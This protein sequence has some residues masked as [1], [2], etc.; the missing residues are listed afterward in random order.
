MTFLGITFFSGKHSID[1]TPSVPE[2]ITSIKI[3]DG[4][5]NHLFVSKNTNLTTNNW[6]DEWDFNTVMNA[7]F[8]E[9]FDAGNSGFSLRNTD[10]VVIR[11]RERLKNYWVTLFTIPI[12]KTEDFAINVLDRYARSETD[13]IYR[14][15]STLHGIENSFVEKEIYSVF[16][17]MYLVDKN[18]SY[19]SI[20]NIEDCDTTQ[21]IKSEVIETYS[22]YPTVCSNS[23]L[24]YESGTT[25]A[26][27]IKMDETCTKPLLNESREYRNEFKQRIA[28]KKPMILKLPDGRLWMVK[29]VGNPG[30]NTMGHQDLRQISFEWVEIGNPDDMKSL[31][32]NDL[33]DVDARWWNY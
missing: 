32:Y 8:D 31:Y 7:S 14:I 26:L 10:T 33:S 24:N 1:P 11:R 3:S 21:N 20:Y 27:F 4:T 15:S 28:S 25:T 13:C 16:D 9:F 18:S 19:G 29:I 22:K 12:N 17:G 5:Y 6:D 2:T 30:E 23:D